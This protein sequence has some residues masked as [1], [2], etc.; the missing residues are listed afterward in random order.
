MGQIGSQKHPT[1]AL[2]I[3]SSWRLDSQSTRFDASGIERGP[4][5]DLLVVR[6]SELAVYVV[7]FRENSGVARLVRHAR[8]AVDGSERDVGVGRFDIEGLA[9]DEKGIRHNARVVASSAG[10]PGQEDMADNYG[11][12]RCRS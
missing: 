10:R 11:A 9:V 2:E 12:G 5:G 6:D 7:K 1:L 3:E 4:N 8:Y